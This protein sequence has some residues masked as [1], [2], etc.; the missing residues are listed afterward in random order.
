MGIVLDGG[1]FT[2]YLNGAHVFWSQGY[3]EP[4]EQNSRW[5]GKVVLQAGEAFQVTGSDTFSCVACGDLFLNPP[6]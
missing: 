4:G 6:S 2:G 3:D 5:R 1:N